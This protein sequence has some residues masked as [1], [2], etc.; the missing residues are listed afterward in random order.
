MINFPLNNQPLP[1]HIIHFCPFVPFAPT[2]FAIARCHHPSPFADSHL[3]YRL[4]RL[5]VTRLPPLPFAVIRHHCPPINIPCHHHRD[6]PCPVAHHCL[7]LLSPV[8][9]VTVVRTRP[10]QPLPLP[11]LVAITISHC[12]CPSLLPFTITCHHCPSM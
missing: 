7:P 8:L 1:L 2:A 6:S 12:H 10:Y 9:P 4:L 11:I 3:A 5:S